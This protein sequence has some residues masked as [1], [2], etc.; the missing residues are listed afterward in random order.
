[1]MVQTTSITVILCLTLSLELRAD[2]YKPTHANEI[3]FEISDVQRDITTRLRASHQKSGL[4]QQKDMTEAVEMAKTAIIKAKQTHDTRLYGR[5]EAFLKPWWKD[6]QQSIEFLYLQAQIFGFNHEF[7]TALAILDKILARE[8]AHKQALFD[9]AVLALVSGDFNKAETMCV[10]LETVHRQAGVICKANIYAVLGQAHESLSTLDKEINQGWIDPSLRQWAL[11]SA[12]E[13]AWRLGELQKAEYYFK[14]AL[15][16]DAKDY[17]VLASYCDFL[18]VLGQPNNVI[19]LLK[20]KQ[21]TTSIL[22][23]LSRAAVQ[24]NHPEA[25]RISEELTNALQ[26]VWESKD[27]QPQREEAYYT[28]Y[29]QKDTRRA[30]SFARTNWQKQKEMIDLHLYYTAAHQENSIQD[31]KAIQQW[32]TQI[33]YQD[34]N[35]NFSQWDRQ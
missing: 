20:D 5:A 1:M 32:V 11:T 23:R 16:H 27:N 14:D 10:K 25:T 35:L 21:H 9:A 6:D 30:L 8:P 13:I 33:G 17:Y 26:G 7:K 12:A 22:L 18:M 29:V 3:V 15:T 4:S 28:L 2:V 24:I 31:L 34:K 19:T